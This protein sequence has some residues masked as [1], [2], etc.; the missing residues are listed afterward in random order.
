M[1]ALKRQL[2]PIG[3]FSIL[4]LSFTMFSVPSESQFQIPQIPGGNPFGSILDLKGKPAIST[5]FSDVKN[6]I[7]L[8][9]SFSPITFR[10]L[11]RMPT[12]PEGGFLLPPGSYEADFQ[13]FCLEA[14]THGPS[15]GDGYLYAPLKGSKA[16]II[17]GLLQRTALHPEVPQSQVQL[18][19]WAIEARAKFADLSPE[20]QRTALTLLTKKEIYELNGGALG[21]VPQS[22]LDRAMDSLPAGER[23][24]VAVQAELRRQLANSEATFAEIEGIAVLAGPAQNNGPIIPRGRWSAHPG[25]FF[26]RYLPNGYRQTRIQVYVPESGDSLALSNRGRHSPSLLFVDASAAAGSSTVRYD[27]TLD[28]AVPANTGAQRLGISE[29]GS[30][31]PTDTTPDQTPPRGSSPTHHKVSVPCPGS[32]SNAV[33]IANSAQ[34]SLGLQNLVNNGP[35]TLSIQALD[36]TGKALPPTSNSSTS[37]LELAPGQRIGKWVPPPGT[38]KVVVACFTTCPG[39]TSSSL[40]Y[41]DTIGVS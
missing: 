31:V 12:A 27:P 19:I 17:Q 3:W 37:T 38:D 36:K 4:V 2:K 32:R 33:T 5:N 11:L 20:V 24:I 28:V 29:A 18:L 23:R 6:E 21:L 39:T 16:G 9:D 8:P 7:V 40:E 34:S 35:C 25:G 13:S 10:P 41:D 26:V 30:D 15:Q 22:V 14:G 1:L